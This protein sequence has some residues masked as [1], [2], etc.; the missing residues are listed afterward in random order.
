M[1]IL[2]KELEDAIYDATDEQLQQHGLSDVVGTGII[3]RFRQTNLGSEAGR[4]DLI[5]VTR[6]HFSHKCGSVMRINIIELKREKFGIE[7]LLQAIRYAY[8]VQ[9]YMLYRKFKQYDIRITVIGEAFEE[10]NNF[11]FIPHIIN[12]KPSCGFGE[13][14]DISV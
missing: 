2:E 13:I 12:R 6:Q 10:N 5:F 1:K 11:M 8:A 3:R 9:S 7:A 14:N 4:S